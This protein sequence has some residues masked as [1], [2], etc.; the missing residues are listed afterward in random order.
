MQSARWTMADTLTDLSKKAKQYW[1]NEQWGEYRNVR[2]ETAEH[3]R[4]QGERKR[5][6][7][8]YMEVMIFDL[9]GVSGFGGQ[10]FTET[11]RG[12]TPSVAREIARFTLHEDLDEGELRAIYD[13][14]VNQFWVEAFP[15]SQEEVWKEADRVVDEY[16]KTIRL[17][18]KVNAL[19]ADQLLPQSEAEAF[20]EGTD[21][22]ELLQ[23]IGALLENESP[24]GIPWEKRKRVHEY[25][26]SIDIDRLG[27]RWKAKAFRWAGEMVLSNNEKEAALEYFENALEIA[28]RDD[29]PTM[30]TLASA[31][32][33]ELGR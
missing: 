13:Q 7:Y 27:S 16:R 11:H 15:R 14:V 12:E 1:S 9:Q 21:D 18:E 5:T 17:K 28:D 8:L 3:V 26:S 33:E 2:Y 24:S 10:G 30:E 6:A 29:Q 20:V 4:R 22:Y 23:R 32:R 25:L 31:L 19:G